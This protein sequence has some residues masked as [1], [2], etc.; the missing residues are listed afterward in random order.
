MHKAVY[1]YARSASIPDATRPPTLLTRRHG[2]R[3]RFPFSARAR[4]VRR[5]PRCAWILAAAPAGAARVGVLRIFVLQIA[6]DSSS[7]S[8]PM[9]GTRTVC[10]SREPTDITP[11]ARAIQGLC[12]ALRPVHL[13]AQWSIAV[14]VL[15]ARTA[16]AAMAPRVS[17]QGNVIS[18]RLV[19]LRLSSGSVDYSATPPQFRVQRRRVAV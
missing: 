3:A 8:P 6:D 14:W 7:L 17:E 12:A 4:P 5:S 9:T 11:R 1:L 13:A 19:A 15:S 18:W 2:A 10:S 16:C